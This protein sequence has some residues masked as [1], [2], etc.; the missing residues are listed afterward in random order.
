MINLKLTKKDKERKYNIKQNH[1]KRLQVVADLKSVVNNI[2]MMLKLQ[3][4][5]SQ[6]NLKHRVKKQTLRKYHKILHSI[7]NSFQQAQ[8]DTDDVLIRKRISHLEYNILEY[9]P[10]E[11]YNILDV[12]LDN[13]EAE[14]K[15]HLYIQTQFN[16]TAEAYNKNNLLIFVDTKWTHQKPEHFYNENGVHYYA[17]YKKDNNHY[18]IT[19]ADAKQIIHD[20][21]FL[22]SEREKEMIINRLKLTGSTLK[23][24]SI[25]LEEAQARFEEKVNFY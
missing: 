24:P 19:Y 18:I 17:Y 11:V 14:A 22:F 23:T 6:K 21:K 1:R 16:P 15:R 4:Q 5:L 2:H 20:Q 3:D 10:D 7:E 12:L 8:Q 25:S 9:T 13:A